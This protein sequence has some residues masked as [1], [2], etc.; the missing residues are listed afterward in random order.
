VRSWLTTSAAVLCA[1]VTLLMPSAASSSPRA[2]AASYTGYGFESCNAPSLDRLQAWLASPYRAIGI[3]IGGATRSC[4]NAQLNAEWTAS[5]LA[6]GWSLIPTYVGLQAPCIS[7]TKRAR[8]T[9]ANAQS[10]GTAAADDAIGDAAALGLPAGIPIYFDLEAYAVKDAA[11]TQAVQ[12]FVSAWVAE[13]HARGYIAGVY[14]SSSSTARDMQPLVTSGI[15]PDNLWFANW[16]NNET[17]FGDPYVSD[18][19]WTN[20]QRIHQYRGGHTETYGGVTINIDSDFVDAAVVTPTTIATTAPAATEGQAGS[21]SSDDGAATARWPATA[22][23]EGAQVTLTPI[24]PGVT[25]AGYGSDG[26]AVQLAASNTVT[27]APVKT[28]AAPVSLTVATRG[29]ALAPLYSSNGRT[30]KRVPALTNGALGAGVRVGYEREDDGS[31]DVQTMVAGTFAFVTDRTRPSP[32]T[33]GPAR[34]SGGSLRLSWSASSD[35]NG[36]IAAY[37]V[38][39]TNRE[40][41]TLPPGKRNDAE[42]GFHRAAP[43]VYRVVAVDAAGNES[44]PSKP[45]VVLPSKRPEDT[46]KAIPAWAWR[47]YDWQQAGKSGSRPQAPKVVPAWYWRW[48]AWR[49]LPFHL[50]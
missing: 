10:S 44:R 25:L 22:F 41:A 38:T 50:R 47:L 20:H 33:L 17:V 3:Y 19:L 45:V 43:S 29:D 23:P 21:A 34:F 2:A 16:N 5:A 30:W 28:F 26:Y 15:G 9:A 11:C 13:L 8:F 49:A 18:N 4:A 35:S 48:A 12:T 6:S 39:L 37:L 14:G 24:A 31:F 7:N 27:L 1:L 42:Q 40:V 46:P 32:P 36:P